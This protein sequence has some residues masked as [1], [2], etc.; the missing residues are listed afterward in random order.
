MPVSFSP[1]RLVVQSEGLDLQAGAATAHSWAIEVSGHALARADLSHPYT[2]V[3][4]Q[5]SLPDRAAMQDAAATATF[6]VR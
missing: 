5:R 1:E 3:A 6:G 4:S 2:R